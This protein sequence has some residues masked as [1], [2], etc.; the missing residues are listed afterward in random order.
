MGSIS[1]HR[2]VAASFRDVQLFPIFQLSVQ[3]LQTALDSIN[4]MSIQDEMQV[5]AL[6]ALSS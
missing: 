1:K 2:K 5:S 4:K 6:F 3:F